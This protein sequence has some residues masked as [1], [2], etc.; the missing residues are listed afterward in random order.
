LHFT[1]DRGGEAMLVINIVDVVLWSLI[2]GLSLLAF[3]LYLCRRR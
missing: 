1:G 2:I 3:V